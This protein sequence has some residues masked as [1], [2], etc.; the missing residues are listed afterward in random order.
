MQNTMIVKFSK[1]KYVWNYLNGGTGEGLYKGDCYEFLKKQGSL[2][3]SEFPQND[4]VVSYDWYTGESEAETVAAL[5]TA[6]KTRLSDYYYYN[7]VA[8]NSSDPVITS[9]K[10]SDLS[11]MKEL[12]NSGYVLSVSTDCNE[13]KRKILSNGTF[14][15]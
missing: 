5:R 11:H 3:W 7:F 1:Q 15:R 12:L 13:W 2:R 14:D 8:E 9:N 4:T 10:D 6:L